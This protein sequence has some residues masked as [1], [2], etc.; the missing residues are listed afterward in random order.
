MYL[1]EVEEILDVIESAEFTK[2]VIPLFS[3]L[4]RCINSQH[5]Q[6]AERAL[7]YWNNEYIVN[8]MGERI[9]LILPIVFPAL[10]QNSRRHWN[11]TITGM[12]LNALKLFMELNPDVFDNV[13]VNYKRQRKEDY[14]RLCQRYDE[15]MALREQALANY[16][17]SGSTQPLPALLRDAPPPRPEPF[18]DHGDGTVDLSANGFDPTESFTLDRSMAEEVVPVADPGIDRGVSSF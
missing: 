3:Q 16:N 2:I 8:L 6:V 5:F 13:Q 4:A 7:Y 17:A 12:V 11:R 9:N 14:E 10:Y 18:E 15:W 1:N